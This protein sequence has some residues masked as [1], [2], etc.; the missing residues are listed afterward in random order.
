LR[1]LTLAEAGPLE[2][3]PRARAA[4]L[5]GQIALRN[6]PVEAAA[7]LWDAAAQLERLDPRLARDIYLEAVAAAWIAGPGT[8]ALNLRELAT[9]S[10]PP[11]RRVQRRLRERHPDVGDR[12]AKVVHTEQL[13]PTTQRRLPDQPPRSQI[14]SAGW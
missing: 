4:L 10:R 6:R 11:S 3:L 1:L 8:P 13:K 7:L 9:V 2:A 14:A 5:R 12:Q